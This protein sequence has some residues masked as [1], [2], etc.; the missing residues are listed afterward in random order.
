[1]GVRCFQHDRGASADCG[2]AVERIVCSG[3]SPRGTGV[4]AAGAARLFRWAQGK[5]KKNSVRLAYWLLSH[6]VPKDSVCFLCTAISGKFNTV[7]YVYTKLAVKKKIRIHTEDALLKKLFFLARAKVLL[8]DQANPLLSSLRIHKETVCVQCWHSS[9]LYKKV[10]YDAVRKGYALKDEENRIRR[11]HGNISY[12][13]ISDEK[14]VPAYAKAFRLPEEK[15]LPLGLC[16]TDL[17]FKV[18]PEICRAALCRNYGLDPQKKFLLYAPTFRGSGEDRC[19]RYALDIASL[20][21][22]LGGQWNFL[23][24][25][26]PSVVDNALEGAGWTDVSDAPQELCLAAA[27]AMVTDYSSILFDYSYYHR[28]IYLLVP[29]LEEYLATERGLYL[30]PKDLGASGV[31][32]STEEIIE[33]LRHMPEQPAPIGIW[34]RF[35]SACDGRATERVCRFVIRALQT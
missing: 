8:A 12:F 30:L 3:Q 11:I 21:A 18:K 20:R 31:C 9:G 33:C 27:D 1:M 26:H 34:E 22:A 28:P 19:H 35:M 10:G 23:L 32:V 13:I 14:L 25:R 2:G 17:L 6:T 5:V 29:D 16:R 24:R 4:P 15:V 7:E